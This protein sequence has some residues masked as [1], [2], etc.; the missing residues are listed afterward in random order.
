M[1][2][3]L[4]VLFHHSKNIPWYT[5][6]TFRTQVSSQDNVRICHLAPN[7]LFFCACKLF[8]CACKIFAK[9]NK[10]QIAICYLLSLIGSL[11]IHMPHSSMAAFGIFCPK[12]IGDK[13]Q[14]QVPTSKKSE[15]NKGIK[16]STFKIDI[17]KVTLLFHICYLLV[18]KIEICLKY[19][20][21]HKKPL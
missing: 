6:A 14:L 9:V 20:N 12:S 5:L 21:S 1:L 19:K 8:F 15:K 18:P 4:F 3:V 17:T 10:I 11:K 2:E 7:K 16:N 13:S